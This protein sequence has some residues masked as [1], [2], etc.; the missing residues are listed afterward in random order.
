VCYSQ[1]YRASTPIGFHLAPIA[2]HPEHQS[3]GLG[4]RIIRQTLLESPIACHAVFVLGDP[5]YYARFGFRGVERPTCPFDANNEHFMALRY[6]L[7]E[8]F[9]IGYEAEFMNGEQDAPPP[10]SRRTSQD[11]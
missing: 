3:R 1:A 2:V 7:E 4:S 10:E 9:Q 5:S 8:D 6:E 11:D